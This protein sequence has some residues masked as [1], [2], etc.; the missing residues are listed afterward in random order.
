MGHQG[1]QDMDRTVTDF[2][3][4]D[5]V[6][7]QALDWFVRL[8]D[9]KQNAATHAD[10]LAWLAKDPRHEEEF[11]GLEILWNS[12]PFLDALKALPVAKP[13]VRRPRGG[14]WSM[15]A[16]ALAASVL[17]AAGI[18]QYPALVVALQADYVTAT[19]AQRRVPLPDGSTLLLNT[20]TAVA[21]DFDAG[22]RHVRLLRGEAFF[23]VVHDPAHPFTVSGRYGEVTVLGTAFA[24][25]TGPGED[26]V[27]LERGRVQVLCLCERKDKAVL[28]P[29]QAV[30]V[31]AS[32][33]SSVH[34]ADPSATLAWREGRIIFE[35]AL[36][37]DVLEEL[38]RYHR[39]AILVADERVN[40]M[41]VTGNYRLD[42]VDG[43]VRTL[44]DAAGVG[45]YRVPGGLIILR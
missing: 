4:A 29:G 15:R 9:G 2:N 21:L 3:H 42:D 30:S 25:R 36:L 17:V 13:E 33:V 38:G 45:F 26:E 24:V 35:D 22:R 11:R 8:R 23:D 19:G 28:A 5:P 40:Q 43:A 31:T 7:D 27:V 41:R 14:R 1:A 10:F 12:K 39:G 34:A 6:A 37:G 16:A 32:A 18:W 44:A 20:D